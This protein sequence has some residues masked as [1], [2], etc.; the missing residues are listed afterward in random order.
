GLSY[1]YFVAKFWKIFAAHHLSDH[2]GKLSLLFYL[3]LVLSPLMMDQMVF[4]MESWLVIALL[5]AG[6]IQLL[7]TPE[8]GAPSHRGSHFALL[9]LMGLLGSLAR[10]DFG[11]FFGVITAGS[12]LFKVLRKESPVRLASSLVLTMGAGF[13]VVL[14]LLHSYL[15]SGAWVQGSAAMKLYWSQLMGFSIKPVFQLWTQLVF[16]FGGDLKLPL[17]LI[18]MCVGLTRLFRQ[19]E[20]KS[21][22]WVSVSIVTLIGYFVYYRHNSQAI[23]PWYVGNLFLPTLIL[24]SLLGNFFARWV[25]ALALAGFMILSM[26]SFWGAHFPWQKGFYEAGV[27]LKSE[28]SISKVAAWNAGVLSWYSGNKVTNIDGLTNDSVHEFIRNGKLMDF[29]SER[30]LS[31]VLDFSAMWTSEDRAQRGGY[32]NLLIHSQCYRERNR[33][34]SSQW[35]NSDLQ[36]IEINHDCLRSQ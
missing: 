36:M 7:K 31:R 5:L 11:L 25:G 15:I 34:T 23:Q 21:I 28:S 16:P 29:L 3:G 4:L 24:G 20:I 32:R 6:L 13:G 8:G 19:K 26:K 17:I 30:N 12:L 33:F 35:Q 1:A 10:T 22:F 27:W 18:F 9:F 14:S 2:S